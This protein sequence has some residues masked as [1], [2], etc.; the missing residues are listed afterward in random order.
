MTIELKTIAVGI[1]AAATLTAAAQEPVAETPLK[2]QPLIEE[3]LKNRPALQAAKYEADAKEAEIGPQGAYDDPMV[4]FTA[5]NYPA[6]TRSPGEFGMT[7]NE[8][9][10]TQRIPFPGKLSKLRNAAEHEFEAKRA[11]YDKKQ[12]GLVKEVKVAFFEL[13][14]AYR[15]REILNEQLSLIAQLI[16]VARSKYALNKLTQAELLGLQ[17]EEG[18]LRDQGLMVE[19]QIAVKTGDLN[20]AMGRSKH[21]YLPRPEDVKRTPL[22]LSKVTEQ[23]LGERVLEKNPGLKSIRSDLESAEERHSF[24]KWNYLPDFELKLAYTQRQP[25]PGDRGVDFVSAGVALSLPLWAFSKQSEQLKGASAERARAKALLDEERIHMLHMVHTMYSE[26]Q[27]AAKRLNLYEGGL[28]PLA[29]QS[30]LS[31]KSAYLTGRI[32]YATLNSLIRNRFQTEIA[33]NEALVNYESRLAEFEALV[34]EPLEAQ[35]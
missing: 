4:G 22:D 21:H 19:K 34:G 7:G 27:E 30:V 31:A 32:D 1:L 8:W 15:K 20:H 24:A 3:A 26:L 14:L 28:V 10:V 13:F 5:M 9:S 35:R 12:L 17:S 23:A 2:L 6:D 29:R 18:N 11:A 16:G 33:Y 25:S